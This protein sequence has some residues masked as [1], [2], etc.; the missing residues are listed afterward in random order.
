MRRLGLLL[1]CAIA[2]FACKK[3]ES[4][5]HTDTA[6]LDTAM[7][8]LT[9]HE[10]SPFGRTPRPP[11][12]PMSAS[13]E[14]ML[15]RGDTS[16][17]DVTKSDFDRAALLPL[18]EK[19]WKGTPFTVLRDDGSTDT[20]TP[21]AGVIVAQI[22]T[23]CPYSRQYIDFLKDPATAPYVKGKKLVFL[24]EQDEWPTIRSQFDDALK[25]G[26]LTQAKV[27]ERIAQL[28]DD[29]GNAPVYDPDMLQNLPGNY[30]FLPRDSKV[31]GRGFPGLY[32]PTTQKCTEHPVRAFQRMMPVTALVE[33]WQRHDPDK[34]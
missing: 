31:A 9:T 34:S 4:V 32:T 7:T 27:D 5:E 20:V 26:E 14:D 18:A 29:A 3:E 17:A 8:A 12:K 21:G 6:A 19:A 22:A 33:T 23:W 1:L 25:S 2:L 28:K 16:W 13:V 24:L 15:R 11:I 10:H 30:Y